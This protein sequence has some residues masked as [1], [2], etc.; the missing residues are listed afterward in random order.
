MAK[1]M[2]SPGQRPATRDVEM[3]LHATNSPREHQGNQGSKS[4]G[5]TTEAGE[6]ARPLG[7][8]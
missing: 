2:L 1:Y 4:A 3:V 8:V 6:N 5:Q 7:L